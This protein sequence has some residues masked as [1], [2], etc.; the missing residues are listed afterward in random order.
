MLS[1]SR[2]EQ[3]L[4]VARRA[5][6]D[7][8]Q[9]IAA[10]RPT[11]V[12]HKDAGSTPASQIVTEVDRGSQALILEALRPTLSTDGLGLLTEELP[13]DGSRHRAPA[14]WCIDPLDGTLPFVEGRPGYAV[15]IGLVARD[16][17]PLLGVVYDPVEQI[18]YAARRGGGL[19]R[20]GERWPNSG[21]ASA[22]TL[23]VFA[24]ASFD[25]MP[26]LPA[27]V[28][29]L[30][31]LAH[32]LGLRGIHRPPTAAAVCN[33]CGVLGRA[34]AVYFKPPK[35]QPGGGSLWDYAA[36]AC[37]YGETD[38]VATD[39]AGRPLDLNRA[40]GT[41]MNHRGI[42]FASDAAVAAGVRGLM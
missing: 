31:R 13:D 37:L 16:A 36:T 15:S 11:Q 12:E 26:G 28:A 30:Q 7:A 4:A 5:A 3:L 42:I 25:R 8:G 29:G 2:L 21:A 32:D 10:Q 20:N 1:P 14:F 35:P 40:D 17:T 34:P 41:F 33:A 23:A 6:I 9:W 39:A 19:L 24:D 27:V 18:V 22:D 38:A